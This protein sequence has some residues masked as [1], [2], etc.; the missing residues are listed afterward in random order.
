[1]RLLPMQARFVCEY[2]KSK[3]GTQAAINAGYKPSNAK[4]A[5]IHLLSKA[6]IRD[7]I[8][9][10]QNAVAYRA[11][12]AVEDVLRETMIV[13]FSS[14][15]DYLDFSGDEITE[16]RASEVDETKLRALQSI[17][18]TVRTITDSE[19]NPD[20]TRT[21]EYKLWNKMDALDKLA[22]HFGMFLDQAEIDRLMKR[23][24]E[25]KARIEGQRP[26]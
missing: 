2:A 22:K 25:F 15:G 5:A 18:I 24:D 16:K 12:L 14:L 6:T 26:T 20:V 4:G 21:V 13:A 9:D 23:A 7:A 8:R 10:K 11:L 19:G 17:K 1:M 3:N